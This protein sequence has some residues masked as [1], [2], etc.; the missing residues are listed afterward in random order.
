VAG[1]RTDE[2]PALERFFSAVAWIP[3]GEDVARAAGESACKHRAAHA[4][5]DDADYSSP[6]RRCFSR[7]TR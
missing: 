7:P 5:I 4:G 1:A 3:I 6:P 2:L